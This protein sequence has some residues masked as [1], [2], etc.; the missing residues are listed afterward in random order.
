MSITTI[1][2]IQH[3]RGLKTDLPENLEEGELGWCMDTQEL[4]IGNTPAEGGNTQ[5]LTANV[6]LINQIRYQYMSTT[7]VSAITGATANQPTVRSLQDQLD[8]AWV[9]VRAYGAQGDGITDDTAAIQ[10]AINDSYLKQVS[11]TEHV[12]QSRKAI[13]FPA[14]AYM[15]SDSLKLPPGVHMVGENVAHTQ[16]RLSQAAVVNQMIQLQDGAGQTHANLGGNGAQLPS[17]IHVENIWFQCDAACDVVVL[18]RCDHVHFE[19]C[20]IQGAWQ[21]GTSALSPTVGVKI[22]TLGSAVFTGNCV[23]TRCEIRNVTWAYYCEDPVQNVQFQSCV[24]TQ[25][26]KG[27]VTDTGAQSG[28]SYTRVSSC[29]FDGVDDHGVQ[30]QNATPGVQ[31]TQNLFLDVADV[32][33]VE[34]IYWAVGTQLCTSMN[35]MFGRTTTPPARIFNGEPSSNMVV[36]AQEP[37]NMPV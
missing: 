3:R 35:D 4:F 29:T 23:F 10:R 25:L 17:H 37:L 33:Q 13:W 22:A 34:V 15:I 36:N 24:F 26:F 11:N 9:N 1:A 31:L 21:R 2:R 20:R 7:K 8:D 27:V 12:N 6:S 30:V 19:N 16:I 5:V 32:S 14:G 18:H 28:P